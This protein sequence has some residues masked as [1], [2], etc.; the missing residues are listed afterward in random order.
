MSIVKNCL[1]SGTMYL[2]KFGKY[3][4]VCEGRSKMVMHLGT[5][6]KLMLMAEFYKK[7]KDK[8]K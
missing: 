8:V 1:E 2:K 6:E 5:V 7:H 3:Y 4:K